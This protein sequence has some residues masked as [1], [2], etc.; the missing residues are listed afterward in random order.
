MNEFSKP[1]V[2]AVIAGGLATPCS[3][4]A[5]LRDY[6]KSILS[7]PDVVLATAIPAADKS[8]KADVVRTTSNKYNKTGQV[9]ESSALDGDEFNISSMVL[10]A[11]SSGS[12]PDT[13]IHQ[14]EVWIGSWDDSTDSPGAVI[15]SEVFDLTG[16]DYQDGEFYEFVFS[17]TFDLAAGSEYTFQTWWTSDDA[18][19]S[20]SWERANG[21]GIIAGGLIND[22]SSSTSFPFSDT[23][24]PT[25]DLV[26]AFIQVPEPSSALLSLAGMSLL[27]FRRGRKH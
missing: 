2:F 25:Q 17:S 24:E 9:I 11:G 19:H 1:F 16:F 18:S 13:G 3:D 14:M 8:G 7:D 23:P 22:S 12:L 26:F 4:A 21:Q 20:L 15:H 10:Q 6:Q 27:L 5:I